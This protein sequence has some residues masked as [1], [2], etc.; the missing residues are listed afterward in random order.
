[1]F[2]MQ[3]F[4][5]TYIDDSVI[6]V[7]SLNVPQG[8]KLL[9]SGPSGSGK[10]TFLH[11]LCGILRPTSGRILVRDQDIYALPESARD[12]FRGRT[13]GIV[14]QQFNLLPALTVIQN[15]MVAQY[16]AGL[17]KDPT[18]TD[19]LLTSLDIQVHRDTF[20]NQLS[21]GQKQRVAIARALVNEPALLLADEPT[22]GLD[23]ENASRAVDLLIEQ[24]ERRNVTLVIASH[25]D[26]VRP[27][28]PDTYKL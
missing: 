16:A 11:V 1:M 18:R 17:E 26:R 27:R 4:K 2:S 24:S 25:D 19:A 28:I 9:V 6:S 15:L 3:N 23:D 22:S 20:P 14:L 12:R 8:G 5:H 21:Y 7:D 10:T 13:I